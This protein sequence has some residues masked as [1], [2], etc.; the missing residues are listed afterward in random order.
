ML[1]SRL[2][3]LPLPSPVSQMRCDSPSRIHRS[4]PSPFAARLLGTEQGTGDVPFPGKS[5]VQELAGDGLREIWAFR[6]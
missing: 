6:L 3:T 2:P 4:A 1:R 5:E